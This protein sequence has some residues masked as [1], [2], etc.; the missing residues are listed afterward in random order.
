MYFATDQNTES[1]NNYVS[2]IIDILENDNPHYKAIINEIVREAKA[3]SSSKNYYSVNRER[4]EIISLL[5]EH[6]PLMDS[7]D[8]QKGLSAQDF[9]SILEVLENENPVHI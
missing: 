9:Q 7:I 4:F 2:F 5:S 3:L 1:V 6:Q 8:T